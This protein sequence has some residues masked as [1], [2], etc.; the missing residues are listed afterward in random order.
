MTY[1]GC[2]A[3]DGWLRKSDKG[4]VAIIWEEM[5]VWCA[6]VRERKRQ[7]E[8]RRL[9]GGEE[10]RKGSMQNACTTSQSISAS[11]WPL[12]K[13]FLV[14]TVSPFQASARLPPAMMETYTPPPAGQ[15]R[16]LLQLSNK[17]VCKSGVGI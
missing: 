14:I 1:Y 5:C 10:R 13:A 3:E 6:C 17:Q 11:V 16:Q 7:R 8:R 2:R 12:Y 4:R 15:L 9:R